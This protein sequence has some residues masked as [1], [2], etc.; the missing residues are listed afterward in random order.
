MRILRAWLVVVVVMAAF[1]ACGG[2]ETDEAAGGGSESSGPAE[3]TVGESP[4]AEAVSESPPAEQASET[5]YWDG[6]GF[7]DRLVYQSGAAPHVSLAL[8]EALAACDFSDED[9]DYVV[10]T[11]ETTGAN[12]L[13]SS[14]HGG[15]SLEVVDLG[16]G[17]FELKVECGSE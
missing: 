13:I 12:F 5:D 1:A 10:D 4:P 14:G 8:H 6:S 11:F 16:G 17:V 9:A 15:S 3:T 2:S 7:G